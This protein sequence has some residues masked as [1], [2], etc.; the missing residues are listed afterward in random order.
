M[1]LDQRIE[2]AESCVLSV[3]DRVLH[4]RGVNAGGYQAGKVLALEESGTICVQFDGER[5]ALTLERARLLKA[6]PSTALCEG[7]CVR[8]AYES[9][10]LPD[11]GMR[12]QYGSLSTVHPGGELV[13]VTFDNG[14]KAERVPTYD[15]EAVV[16]AAQ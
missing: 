11:G 6:P 10:E 12:W 3:N 13:D 9:E 2:T 16:L 8:V 15:V 14:E 1:A 4:D 5:T 7:S